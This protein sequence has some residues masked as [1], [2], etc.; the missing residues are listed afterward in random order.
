MRASS[1]LSESLLRSLGLAGSEYIAVTILHEAQGSVRY[2]CTSD[3]VTGPL[4]NSAAQLCAFPSLFSRM[5]AVVQ[6]YWADL[7][8]ELHGIKWYFLNM[9]IEINVTRI[10][11]TTLGTW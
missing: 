9:E 2:C 10:L 7:C 11:Y 5:L 3:P 8:Q 1:S 4:G 6:R